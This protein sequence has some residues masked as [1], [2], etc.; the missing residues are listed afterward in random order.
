MTD[1]RRFTQPLYTV[2]GAAR[3]VGMPP[4]TLASWAK[5]YEHRF[6]HRATVAKGPVI[7]A[8]DA[9]FAG[10]PS[11]PFI[12]LVEAMVVQAFRRTDLSLQ[13]IRQALAVLTSQG[14]LH[15]ALASRKLYTDGAEILYDYARDVGDGQLGLLTVV[16]SGQRVFHDIVDAYLQRIHFDHDPWATE[17]IVPVT[18]R[19]ILRIRPDVASG[20]A[21]FMHGGAPL[22]A[23]TSRFRA[24]EPVESIAEDYE[25]PVDDVREALGA[26]E[27]TPIAA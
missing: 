13:R 7:T 3:L 2:T 18:E 5:G 8:V 6:P 21:L 16:R 20:D 14:E 10:G 17:I 27:S 23:V 15:N 11:I 1:D 9:A 4:S 25:L 22:S 19:E 24:G 26:I 12:G